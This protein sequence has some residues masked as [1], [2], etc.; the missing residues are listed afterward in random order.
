MEK[1]LT[2]VQG[3]DFR[4]L[5]PLQ[6]D[7]VDE[8]F[9][10]APV[11]SFT[12]DGVVTRTNAEGGGIEVADELGNKA[13]VTVPATATAAIDPGPYRAQSKVKLATDDEQVVWQGVITFQPQVPA[14]A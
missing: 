3:T 4:I 7:G 2:I 6:R 5:I 13:I 8:P 9:G 10:S 12:I 1:H 11:V 14:V